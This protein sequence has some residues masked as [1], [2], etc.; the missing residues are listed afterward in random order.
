MKLQEAF[1]TS[2]DE[3]R[4]QMLGVQVLFGFQF[5]SLFQDSF[6]ELDASTRVVAAVGMGCM[7]ATL[8][9]LFT[10]PC[11]HRITEEGEINERIFR[12]SG[13]YANAALWS[14]IPGVGC[15]VYA[16]LRQPFGFGVA[17]GVATAACIL[18]AGVWEA[19]ALALRRRWNTH[20][21]ETAM[22]AGATTLH[23]KI[24]DMLTEAR[25]ILPGAQALLGFQLLVTLSHA[26]SQL[27]PAARVFHLVALGNLLLAII[28]LIAP[29]ALHRMTFGGEDDA[30][31]HLL[32]SRIIAAALLPFAI[33][34]SCDVWIACM[35]LFEDTA[36]ASGLAVTTLAGLLCLWYAIPFAL[37]RR[38]GRHH[39]APD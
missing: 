2:L 13:T 34:L 15:D 1:K 10:A 28:L 7:V 19:L 14:F 9:L 33:A 17:L 37:R 22:H 30:R 8:A 24:E 36:W 38:R 21:E 26:F 18:A 32:G 29:A 12:V 35:R 11:R 25:V 3:T 4:M 23:S 16:A 20:P 6:D 27:S 31:L 5:Q 39:A